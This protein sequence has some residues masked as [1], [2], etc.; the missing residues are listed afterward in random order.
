MKSLIGYELSFG[1][2]DIN[3]SNDKIESKQKHLN[4]IKNPR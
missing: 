3:F 2:Q 1:D 4:E